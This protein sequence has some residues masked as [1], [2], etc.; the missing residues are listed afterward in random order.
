[1][2]NKTGLWPVNNISRIKSRTAL[3]NQDNC[4]ALIAV[5][6]SLLPDRAFKEAMTTRPDLM[7]IQDIL[8]Q[9]DL[10]H[11]DIKRVASLINANRLRSQLK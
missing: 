5:L 4:C 8:K 2:D 9:R 6:H 7:A 3:Q 1:M 11:F 10:S